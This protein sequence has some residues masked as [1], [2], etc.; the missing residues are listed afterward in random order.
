MPPLKFK[1][2]NISINSFI[3]LLK[4]FEKKIYRI[5]KYYDKFSFI[6]LFRSIY[7]PGIS[8][9][10]SYERL[11]QLI[12]PPITIFPFPDEKKIPTSGNPIKDLA[13]QRLL[14]SSNRRNYGTWV[15]KKIVNS[16]PKKLRE[17]AD[18]NGK[19]D[20]PSPYLIKGSEKIDLG[21]LIL[22][23]D[24]LLN[25][26]TSS[27]YLNFDVP[28][29]FPSSW[30]ADIG[31]AA[32]WH[33]QYDVGIGTLKSANG[34]E[35]SILNRINRG[36]RNFFNMSA[37]ISDLLGNAD[38]YG[39]HKVLLLNNNINKLSEL[40][41]EYYLNKKQQHNVSKRWRIFCKYNKLKFEYDFGS[42]K[43]KWK[44]KKQTEKLWIHYI[45][46]FVNLYAIES[47][48]DK[49]FYTLTDA[50]P[51][52]KNYNEN[53]NKITIYYRKFLKYIETELESEFRKEIN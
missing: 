28:N 31:I 39:L 15:D 53:G 50:Q 45:N 20:N 35:G 52:M 44:E 41:E 49:T 47:F 16:I 27:P 23:L 5:D 25:P 14:P 43:I 3:I 2:G 46:N 33:I 29:I 22:C 9:F 51:K 8:H 36:S 7:Y 40:F 11:T 24:A 42:G 48:S 21:H 1:E 37:P 17:K 19:N 12:I 26:R 13:F 38:G 32:Y 10:I 34:V 6:N 18:E 30:V 4:H